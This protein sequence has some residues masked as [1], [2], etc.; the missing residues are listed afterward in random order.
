MFRKEDKIDL[1]SLARRCRH[2][3]ISETRRILGFSKVKQQRSPEL[4]FLELVERKMAISAAVSAYL[5]ETRPGLFG[6]R[7]AT[8]TPTHIASHSCDT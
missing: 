2:R 4:P 8:I 1:V 6:G 3:V 7:S 5:S